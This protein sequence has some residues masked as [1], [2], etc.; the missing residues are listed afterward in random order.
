MP[1]PVLYK[2]PV[3]VVP[4]LYKPPV[5]VLLQLQPLQCRLL[6]EVE[7]SYMTTTQQRGRNSRRE[8]RYSRALFQFPCLTKRE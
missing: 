3:L 5:L 2:P 6:W 8:K 4:V 1:V 7:A